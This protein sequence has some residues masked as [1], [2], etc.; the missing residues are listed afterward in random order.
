VIPIFLT[1]EL[2]VSGWQASRSD[3]FTPGII[4]EGNRWRAKPMRADWRR[5]NVF[6]LGI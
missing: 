2:D 4:Y 3:R 5:K 6:I 1:V